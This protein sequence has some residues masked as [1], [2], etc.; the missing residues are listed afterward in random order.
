[1]TVPAQLIALWAHPRSRSTAFFRMMQ[2]RGDF[3]V[4]HEPFCTR[5][6][7]G[8]VKIPDGR[9]GTLSVS[10]ERDLIEVLLDLSTR[11]PVFFKETSEHRYCDVEA[12]GLF[13]KTA[14][15][16]FIVRE[17]KSTI[18]SHYH[19]KSDVSRDEIGYGNLYRM[20]QVVI[21]AT[22]R[23]ALVFEADRL[24]NDT[25]RMVGTFCR[26][27]GLHFDPSHLSW[28][29]ENKKEWA[30]TKAWHAEVAKSSGFHSTNIPYD[31]TVDNNE[32]LKDFYKHHLK[33]YKLLEEMSVK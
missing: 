22:Q 1:M 18:A 25:D 23:Q 5:A 27:F 9:G 28:R 24:V 12:S 4:I 3:L 16:C 10:S 32:I 19:I 8:L 14:K 21:E 26:R 33:Y 17:P 31:I 2:N 13:L 20:Y 6:D 7:T 11:F 29:P 15:H 30:R